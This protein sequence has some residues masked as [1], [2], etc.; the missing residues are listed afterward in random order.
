MTSDSPVVVGARRFIGEHVRHTRRR[1]DQFARR[2]H[3]PVVGT[4]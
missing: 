1:N 4:P 3:S 2:D